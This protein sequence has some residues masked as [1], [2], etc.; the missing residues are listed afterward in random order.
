MSLITLC[1]FLFLR[2]GRNLLLA[3]ALLIFCPQ[4][5]AL[6][7]EL[8]THNEAGFSCIIPQ[9]W[10]LDKTATGIELS[11]GDSLLSVE[12]LI[13]HQGKFDDI[14]QLF[15]IK[16][17]TKKKPVVK[18]YSG[19]RVSL[20][21]DSYTADIVFLKTENGYFLLSLEESGDNFNLELFQQLLD[22]FR[23]VALASVATEP[24]AKKTLV[25]VPT[26]SRQQQDIATQA[27]NALGI[28]FDRISALINQ[29]PLLYKEL[30]A[31]VAVASKL[32]H[33][34]TIADPDQRVALVGWQTDKN[35]SNLL[36]ASYKVYLQTIKQYHTSLGLLPKGMIIPPLEMTLSRAYVTARNKL[37]I[38]QA[39]QQI[40]PQIKNFPDMQQMLQQLLREE[41][42]ATEK[43]EPK[44]Q[45]YLAKKFDNFWKNRLEDNYQQEKFR[46]NRQLLLRRLWAASNTLIDCL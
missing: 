13:I 25:A 5:N 28:S 23:L 20:D 38:E 11:Q 24:A 36:G 35:L 32:E 15:D 33:L 39:Y 30:Q 37:P 27:S 1:K 4:S 29:H 16:A 17:D 21:G 12:N 6:A 42:A 8:F 46:Q 3:F 44:R 9:N 22:S 2:P 26:L 43:I 31:T 10:T 34:A 7:A 14:L 18:P 41:G 45:K 19:V 40:K